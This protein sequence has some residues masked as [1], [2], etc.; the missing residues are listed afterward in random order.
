[1][2]DTDG[3]TLTAEAEERNAPVAK[4]VKASDFHSDNRRFESGQEYKNFDMKKDWTIGF[5]CT[6]K[7]II[8]GGR[9][10]TRLGFS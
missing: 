9:A 3:G 5:N 1:M 4:L 6:A 8:V 2:N 10:M 7:D